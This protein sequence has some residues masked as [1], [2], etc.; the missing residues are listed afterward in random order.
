MLH[1]EI[2]ISWPVN[3]VINY[4]FV[5]VLDAFRTERV[6]VHYIQ[7]NRTRNLKEPCI[8][9]SNLPRPLPFLSAESV[10]E[11]TLNKVGKMSKIQ[12]L[13]VVLFLVDN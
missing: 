8:S 12:L 11:G 9:S 13:P 1:I 3:V 2:G 5:S 4:Y 7:E 6:L 10:V